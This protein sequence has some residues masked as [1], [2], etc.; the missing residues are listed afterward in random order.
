MSK[1]HLLSI[2]LHTIHRP[3]C[4]T[5]ASTPDR[6]FTRCLHHLVWSSFDIPMSESLEGAR[7]IFLLFTFFPNSFLLNVSVSE[8]PSIRWFFF[9]IKYCPFYIISLNS[10]GLNY[11]KSSIKWPNIWYLDSSESHRYMYM[12]TISEY[13]FKI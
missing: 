11:I 10:K 12:Y 4:C 13:S 8:I 3:L 9:G 6:P 7:K 1:T 5:M 2:Y